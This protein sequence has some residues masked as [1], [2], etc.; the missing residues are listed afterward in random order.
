MKIHRSSWQKFAAPW[1]KF[2]DIGPLRNVQK[3]A[4]MPVF[5]LFLAR[6]DAIANAIEKIR[7]YLG[8]SIIYPPRCAP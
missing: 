1:Q 2:A 5:R 6:F 3:E 7:C 4:K 8:T